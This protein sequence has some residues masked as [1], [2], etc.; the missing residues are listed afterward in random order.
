MFLTTPFLRPLHE[1]PHDYYR[2]TPSALQQLAHESDLVVESLIPR[3]EYFAVALLTLQLP[4]S[5][6]W[7]QAARVTRHALPYSWG[8]PLVFATIVAPQLAYLRWWKAA[9][10]RRVGVLN[11]LYNRLS[12]YTLGYVTVLRARR[13]PSTH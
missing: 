9:R 2:F 12:Y 6:L 7:Q 5:K 4:I 10:A 1:M 13:S 8:N 11:R 3:G